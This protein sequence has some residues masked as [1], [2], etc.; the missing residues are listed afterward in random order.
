M[1]EI[2]LNIDDLLPWFEEQH[3]SPYLLMSVPA[4]TADGWAQELAAAIRRCYIDDDD[5]TNRAAALGQELGGTLESRQATVIGAKL[6]DPG[7]TMA[8]D[9]GEIITYLFQAVR[10]HPQVAFGPKKWRLKQD[11]TKPAPGADVIHF[12]LPQWPTP[13]EDDQLLCAEVKTKS[14][15]GTSSPI[16]AAIADSAKDRTSRLAKTLVWLRDKAIIQSL[17]ATTLAHLN[18]FIKATDHPKATRQFFAVAVICADLVEAEL[19]DAPQ[20][21]PDGCSVVVVVVPDLK[22][23]YEAC[24]AAAK[25]SIAPGGS[26][27]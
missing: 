2:G 3:D 24:F 5:L 19:Q 26:E 20:T 12:V 8:G 11:R 22:A 17:G 21:Q 14:T 4:E 10:H 18:R 23:V 25:A 1:Q 15:S 16:Q 27:A 13:C 7:S 9:F 6:P